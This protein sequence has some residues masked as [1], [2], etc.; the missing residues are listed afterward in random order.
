MD[1]LSEKLSDILNNPESLS[2]V[3]Q[4]AENILGNNQKPEEK[5]TALNELDSV[6]GAGELQSVISIIE[7]LKSSGND[8]RSQLLNALKPHLSKPKRE[9][10][11]TAIK[12]L[13]VIEIL[14]YLRESGILNL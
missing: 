9:K 2:Q 7:K 13:K 14:P 1:E 4:M 10:A 3:R 6:L 8:P 12:I 11:D 5:S